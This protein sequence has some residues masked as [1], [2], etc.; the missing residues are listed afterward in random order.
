MIVSQRS[1]RNCPWSSTLWINYAFNLEKKSQVLATTKDAIATTEETASIKTV[2]NQALNAGLQTSEDY[3][4]VWHSYLD[5]LKRTFLAKQ[6]VSAENNE[7][8]ID[9][10]RDAFQKAINQLFDCKY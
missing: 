5:F 6:K 8:Q 2:F 7:E 1:I 10:I 4:Q 3:L 9:E